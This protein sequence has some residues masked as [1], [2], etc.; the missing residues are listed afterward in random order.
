MKSLLERFKKRGNIASNTNHE[1]TPF[2][3]GMYISSSLL[4]FREAHNWKH[5]DYVAS[6]LAVM[7]EN[8][9]SFERGGR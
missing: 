7:G 1:M 8:P 4:F 3:A 2:Q 9:A 5:Q 6:F